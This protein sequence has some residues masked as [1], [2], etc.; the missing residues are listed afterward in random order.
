MELRLA[1][2][3]DAVHQ[4]GPVRVHPPCWCESQSCALMWHVI[5]AHTPT[6]V[7]DYYWESL[8]KWNL[9]MLLHQGCAF[10]PF[11]VHKQV[12]DG[13]WQLMQSSSAAITGLG[14]NRFRP[15]CGSSTELAKKSVL[16]ATGRNYWPQTTSDQ[17]V[18]HPSCWFT[19]SFAILHACIFHGLRSSLQCPHWAQLSVEFY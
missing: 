2:L 10:Y 16:N 4:A 8:K 14:M 11:W 18:C 7:K 1:L 13:R 19:D 17:S 3:R 15:I 5:W 12:L 9:S 6:G